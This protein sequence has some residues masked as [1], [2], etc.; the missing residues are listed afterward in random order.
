MIEHKPPTHFPAMNLSHRVEQRISQWL[1]NKIIAEK[2]ASLACPF[3]AISRDA[4]ANGR[5]VADLVADSLGWEVLG[6]E[7]VDQM[8]EKYGMPRQMLKFLDETS[9]NWLVE[10]FGQWVEWNTIN[11]EEY[12]RRL[13]LIVHTAAHHGKVVFI[14]RGAQFLL[15]RHRGLAVRITGPEAFRV[16]NIMNNQKISREQAL[17][18]VKNTDQGRRDFVQRY[19]GADASNANLYDL[20]VNSLKIDANLAASIIVKVYSTLWPNSEC[21]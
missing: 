14:G 10:R 17:D 2:D 6:G 7:L 5:K 13:A 11:Q 3:I 1:Q 16:E 8:A 12:V 15:P 19:F 18:Y 9:V 20:V 4:G 21:L